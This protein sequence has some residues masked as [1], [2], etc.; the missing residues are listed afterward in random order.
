MNGWTPVCIPFIVLR[1][2]FEIGGFCN[3]II[4]PFNDF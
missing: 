1:T 2:L 4:R 3:I